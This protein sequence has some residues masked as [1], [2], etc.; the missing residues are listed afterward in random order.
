MEQP[1]ENFNGEHSNKEQSTGNLNELDQI[2]TY[3][4]QMGE[5]TDNQIT[6]LMLMITGVAR[7]LPPPQNLETPLE[8]NRE[9]PPEPN[10][11]SP[12][13]AAIKTKLAQL[14][15]S[16]ARSER[17][18]SIGFDIDELCL[19]PNARLPKKFKPI[20]FAKF[21]RMPCREIRH[22]SLEHSEAPSPFVAI[23]CLGV[24]IGD[25]EI[26]RADAVVFLRD[27][28]LAKDAEFDRSD[29]VHDID[30]I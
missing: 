27:A 23:E 28:Q 30:P 25:A 9:P 7:R 2:R 10:P 12:E 22:F 11:K 18:T 8:N 24:E 15:Q 16:L 4:R 3:I 20:D 17:I 26:P 21:D 19:F 29:I 1:V 6:Q 13:M 5:R 14:E